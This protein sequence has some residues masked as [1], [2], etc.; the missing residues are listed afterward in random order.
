MVWAENPTPN[1]RLDNRL[2]DVAEKRDLPPLGEALRALIDWV[3]R[4]TL[5]RRGMVLRMGGAVPPRR[6]SRAELTRAGR[7]PEPSA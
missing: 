4:Y 5:T 6:R 7:R 3:A 2:K 1:P